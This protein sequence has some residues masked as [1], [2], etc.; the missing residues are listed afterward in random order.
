[1]NAF[2][3]HFRLTLLIAIF[4][5]CAQALLPT[6]MRWQQ[7]VDPTAMTEIC[8][9]FGVQVLSEDG[10]PQPV[11]PGHCPWCMAQ[12][13]FALPAPASEAVFARHAESEP[14][15]A[16]LAPDFP[17]FTPI[18]ASPRAPPRHA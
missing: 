10:T 8:T 17:T 13:A 15:P 2:R 1:M 5:V 12:T 16:Q 7:S 3:T 11:K 6:L 9:V 14:P 18:A 4:A